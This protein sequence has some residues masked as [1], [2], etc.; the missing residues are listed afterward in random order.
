MSALGH[1]DPARSGNRARR[2]VPLLLAVV[3]AGAAAA[4]LAWPKAQQ[5]PQQATLGTDVRTA[6]AVLGTLV[7]TIR[8]AGQS[9]ARNYALMSIPVQRGPEFRG[10]MM[11]LKLA[12]PGSRVNKGDLVIEIDAQTVQDH[13]DDVRDTVAQSGQDI[14]KRKAEQGVDWGN[15]QQT[16]RVARSSLEKAQLEDR[17][18]QVKT[19]V[20]RE[21]LRLNLE[22]AQ[23]SYKQQQADLEASKASDQAELR[24]LE[25]TQA[26]NKIHLDRHLVDIEKFRMKAPM[27]G[28]VVMQ[29]VFRGGEMAQIQEGDQVTPGQQ[30]M[31]IVD[32]TS[33]QVEAVVNQSQSSQL[34]LG[35]PATVGLDAFPEL[36]FKGHVYS[37]GALA[38]RSGRESYY[39]RSVPVRVAI[40]GSDA[41]VIP[42]LS[43]WADIEVERQ[44]NVVLV[45]REAVQ[46][47]GDSQVVYVKRPEGLE[48]RVVI[49]GLSNNSHVA[50]TSGL[51]AGEEVLL[52]APK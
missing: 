29:Q 40:Q 27:N 43:A 44:E 38:A 10:N 12:K 11:L 24:M 8:V 16:L 36:H 48:K 14:R 13:I 23:A 32:S 37:V 5:R 42:D 15:L 1:P 46:L 4:Y 7:R 31:K 52:G 45:P 33:M 22:E 21:L 47:E 34:R 6:K 30:I 2:R 9:S 51:E 3:L 17:A 50:V 49:L 26:Q 18:G 39:I 35:L 25:I 28:L 41:R 20:E 19:E